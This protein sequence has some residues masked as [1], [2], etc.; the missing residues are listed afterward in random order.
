[1]MH[2]YQKTCACATKNVSVLLCAQI[3]PDWW[4]ELRDRPH[5]H[6]VPVVVVRRNNW[7]RKTLD[8]AVNV[9]YTCSCMNCTCTRHVQYMKVHK[10][11]QYLV[12]LSFARTAS[13]LVMKCSVISWPLLA[14]WS[15]INFL[16]SRPSETQTT[17][18]VPSLDWRLGS[19]T[20]LDTYAIYHCITPMLMYAQDYIDLMNSDLACG[21]PWSDELLAACTCR[22]HPVQ[23]RSS[24]L[25][26]VEASGQAHSATAVQTQSYMYHRL[27]QSVLSQYQ[28]LTQAVVTSTI[29]TSSV[30]YG[31]TFSYDKIHTILVLF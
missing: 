9:K 17:T 31:A 25:S 2:T 13:F 19:I 7:K 26:L 11:W 27:T 3:E 1:M 16:F 8:E 23:L 24:H 30:P 4:R 28:R 15:R 10:K 12:L 5:E 18:T 21:W 14:C 6:R 20:G 29:D 22:L